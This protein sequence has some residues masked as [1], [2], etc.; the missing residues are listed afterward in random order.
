VAAGSGLTGFTV[1][2]SGAVGALGDLRIAFG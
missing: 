2:L 1:A